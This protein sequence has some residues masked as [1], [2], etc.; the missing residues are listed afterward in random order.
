MCASPNGVRVL[1]VELRGG[2]KMAAP[3][4]RL[5]LS[6]IPQLSPG[7]L[8]P[9]S[10]LLSLNPL[11]NL[12]PEAFFRTVPVLPALSA[13]TPLLFPAP[14]RLFAS[15]RLWELPGPLRRG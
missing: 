9:F 3:R 5:R 12:S 4:W 11:G 13:A 14:R 1:P 10:A 7:S 15:F 8:L 6:L 2:L